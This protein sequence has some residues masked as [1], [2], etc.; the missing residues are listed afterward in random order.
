MED[1]LPRKIKNNIIGM[2]MP[3]GPKLSKIGIETL[4]I[5]LLGIHFK[6]I[7]WISM[8]NIKPKMKF[9]NCILNFPPPSSPKKNMTMLF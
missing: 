6:K 9:V 2:R 3:G 4:L 8:E 1:H 5:H 7:A